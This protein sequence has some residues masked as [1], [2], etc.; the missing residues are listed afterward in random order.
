METAPTRPN[1]WQIG[2]LLAIPFTGLLSNALLIPVLP[3]IAAALHIPF[4]QATWLVVLPSVVAGLFI[5]VAGYMSDRWTRTVVLAPS[6]ALYGVGGLLGAVSPWLAEAPFTVLL[7][8]RFLQGIG[9]AGTIVLVIALVGDVLGPRRGSHVL[10]LIETSNALGKSSGP[11]IGGALGSIA[12]NAPL[13]LFPALALPVAAALWTVWGRLP[14]PRAERP[15]P[16][17]YA[18]RFWTAVRPK[19]AGLAMLFLTGFWG[20]NVILLMLTLLSRELAQAGVHGWARG[21][22]IT[23]PEVAVGA[24]AWAAGRWLK[25][26]IKV[27]S[28]PLILGGLALLAAGFGASGLIPSTPS[29]FIAAVI[30][31]A[32]AGGALAAANGLIAGSVSD[33][34]RGVVA[35]VYGAFRALGVAIIPLFFLLSP[36]GDRTPAGLW[37]MGGLTVITAGLVAHYLAPEK[38]L[39]SN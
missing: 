4:R 22:L 16:G 38:L 29:L 26:D 12:W 27:R 13:F 25:P 33:E 1:G 37:L 21:A 14:D 5:P 24:A 30:A 19:F 34:G 32:G 10:G 8:A 31:G 39:E 17:D 11:L 18:R 20:V 6:L 9:Y 15:G 2:L 3:K 7:V 28:R 36:G 23:V 35:A